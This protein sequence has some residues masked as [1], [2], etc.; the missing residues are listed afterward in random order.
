MG[1]MTDT[2]SETALNEPLESVRHGFINFVRSQMVPKTLIRINYFNF[3]WVFV[4]GAFLGIVVEAG[5]H[6]LAY[7]QFEQRAG[8]VWGPFSPL[9][10]IGAIILTLTMDR[11]YRAHKLFIFVLS[12]LEGAAIEFFASLLLQYSWGAIAWDYTGTIGS[13]GG[14]TNLL[15]AFMWGL[16]GMFWVHAIMP[17][18]AHVL[19]HFDASSSASKLVTLLFTIFL[20]VDL[21]VTWMALA[22]QQERVAQI[23]ADNVFEEQLDVLYPNDYMDARFHNMSI[24]SSAQEAQPSEDYYTSHHREQDQ[25]A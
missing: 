18:M 16:I 2:K 1:T 23:P 20:A 8:L 3:F 14:R 5:F 12:A 13:V 6:V 21:V 9:Y 10:G 17:A 19:S 15:F 7:G 4:I 25:A 24:M 22:R 11:L